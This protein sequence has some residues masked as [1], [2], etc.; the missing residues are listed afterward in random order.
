[1]CKS[2]SNQLGDELRVDK[3]TRVEFKLTV[4]FVP[5][6][7]L[8]VEM[9]HALG[10]LLFVDRVVDVEVVQV[11]VAHVGLSVLVQFSRARH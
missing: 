9:L 11:G 3:T 1:M 5:V 4:I 7:D 6:L 2:K 10:N 8:V